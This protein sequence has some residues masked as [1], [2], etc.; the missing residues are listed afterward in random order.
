[1]FLGGC[2]LLISLQQAEVLN[3][4]KA[5]ITEYYNCLASQ[6]VE[7]TIFLAHGT[8]TPTEKT[9]FLLLQEAVNAQKKADWVACSKPL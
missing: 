3:F 5:S 1:M 9:R 6:A 2:I 7:Q 4:L 8:Q